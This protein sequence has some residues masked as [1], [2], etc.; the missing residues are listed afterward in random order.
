MTRARGL[1]A[2]SADKVSCQS[3]NLG[4]RRAR[5]EPQ[6]GQAARSIQ[7]FIT[8]VSCACQGRLDRGTSIGPFVSRPRKFLSW[9]ERPHDALH[10]QLSGI[11]SA[12]A[13]EWRKS[14]QRGRASCSSNIAHRECPD[15]LA[16]GGVVETCQRAKSSSNL[17][18]GGGKGL[19][20][21]PLAGLTPD[22][23]TEAEFYMPTTG[24]VGHPIVL[25]HALVS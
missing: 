9:E 24:L 23:R 17:R 18:G 1:V 25:L 8:R 12:A 6:P 3:I 21:V 13:A 20:N 15:C 19:L 7:D 2:Q 22:V 4:A 16:G 5:L 11:A 14:E 10:N